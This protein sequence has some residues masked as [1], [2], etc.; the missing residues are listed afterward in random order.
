MKKSVSIVI[1]VYNR[2]NYLAAAIKSV[3]AQTWSDLELLIWDDGST[4]RSV[5]IAS[6]MPS[7]INASES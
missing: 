6:S 1:T 2:E 4:D 3:L 5:E 7:K